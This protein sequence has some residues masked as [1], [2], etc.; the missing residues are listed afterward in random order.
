MDGIGGGEMKRRD[1]LAKIAHLEKLYTD[2]QPL[3]E[4]IEQSYQEL[5]DSIPE[6]VFTHAAIGTTAD[7]SEEIMSIPAFYQSDVGGLALLR[8][9]VER[10]QYTKAVCY[11][12]FDCLRRRFNR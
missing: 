2:L 1:L 7:H 9:Y 10:S 12:P 4:A 5:T 11:L 6:D 8:R 3:I